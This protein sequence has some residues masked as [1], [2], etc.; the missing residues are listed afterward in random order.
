ELAVEVTL[1]PLRR[2]DFDAAILF[3]DIL[4]VPHALGQGVRFE[5]GHGPMLDAFAGVDRLERDEAVWREKLTPV[6]AAMRDTRA[7]LSGGKTLIGFAGAPWTLAAYMIEG[8]GSP[9]QRSAKL[10]AYRDPILFA[11]LLDV[12]ADA[13][14]WHL[15]QQLEAGADVVQIF[16][17]W[18]G[19]LPEQE[20]AQMVIAPNKR[21]VAKVRKVFPNAKIIGFPRAATETGYAAYAAQTGVDAV[22]IDTAA[23]IGW[24]AKDL[25]GK[26][27]VQGNLD[28]LVLIAGGDAL[29]RAVDHI[30]AE[31]KEIPFIFNLGHG[32]LPETPVEHVAQLVAR[33]RGVA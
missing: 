5:D 9:D 29:N 30:L 27:A 22:S 18:A 11:K 20:F 31:T 17:S 25:G 10:A 21:V 13:V 15:V 12:L 14:A 7:K 8:K 1:Q 33:V 16:D 23:S 28:P 26:V 19:G 24:A 3:S 32:I 2:F 4:V 6:Y